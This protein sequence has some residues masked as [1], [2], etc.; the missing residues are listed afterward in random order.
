MTPSIR[1]ALLCTLASVAA[2]SAWAGQAEV[3]YIDQRKFTDAGNTRWD[4]HSNLGQLRQYIGELAAQQLPA[5]QTLKL[6][7]LDVDLA[8]RVE[9]VNTWNLR[10][11]RGRADWPR[12]TLRYTLTRDG[13]VLRQGEETLSDPDYLNRSWN[14]RDS[15]PLRYEK[16][17]LAQW[18]RQ[19]F[20]ERQASAPR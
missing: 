17:M 7:V 2:A 19:R 6:D 3:N 14:F 15:D 18:M 20:G 9:P 4:E 8:G 10:I 13:E 16:R 11:A 12:L 5:G 1:A